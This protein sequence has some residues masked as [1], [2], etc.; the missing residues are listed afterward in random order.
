M[1]KTKFDGDSVDSLD[2]AIAKQFSAE[3]VSAV[4]LNY[5]SNISQTLLGIGGTYS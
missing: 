5:I 1:E 3:N 2:A 4:R